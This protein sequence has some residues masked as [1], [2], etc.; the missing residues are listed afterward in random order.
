MTAYT[1]LISATGGT[2]KEVLTE[3]SGLRGLLSPDGEHYAIAKRAD[4]VR[5]AGL[6]IIATDTGESEQ[7]FEVDTTTLN[8]YSWSPDS[9]AVLVQG[10]GSQGEQTWVVYRLD[11]S[12]HDIAVEHR[13]SS[14][15]D[16]KWTIGP[17]GATWSECT[18]FTGQCYPGYQLT[19]TEHVP[20]FLAYKTETKVFGRFDGAKGALVPLAGAAAKATGAT[21]CG[22]YALLYRPAA[23]SGQEVFAVYDSDTGKVNVVPNSATGCP[24]VS[25]K[26]A[27]MAFATRSAPIAVDV[28]TGKSTQ[29]AREGKPIAWS[30]DETQ[31]LLSAPTGT[32]RV[33]GDGSGGKEASVRLVKTCVVGTTGKVLASA[34]GGGIVLYDVGADSATKMNTSAFD[35]TCLVTDDG[36]WAYTIG[37]LYDIEG[38]RGGALEVRVDGEEQASRTFAWRVGATAVTVVS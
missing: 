35:Q 3:D 10:T 37:Q 38:A 15:R 13:P 18:S 5:A 4:A 33:A 32:F 34:I 25:S 12:T 2:T 1:S 17:D 28:A 27:K 31:V 24:V 22:R 6:D 36:K 11:G 26:G 20:V 16:T 23:T 14:T 8:V 29:I 19:T 7:S 9:S 21:A 30:K